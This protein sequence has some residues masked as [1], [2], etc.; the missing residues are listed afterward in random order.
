MDYKVRDSG[1]QDETRG[2]GGAVL[3]LGWPCL[4]V[5]PVLALCWP[6]ADSVVLVLAW[7][8]V[9][10]HIAKTSKKLAGL[11]SLTLIGAG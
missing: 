7:P 3:G 5:G 6:C 1:A 8:G 4:C 11:H 9:G 2:G 10:S